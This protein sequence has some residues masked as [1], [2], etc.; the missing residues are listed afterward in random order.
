MLEQLLSSK[1]L[2]SLVLGLLLMGIIYLEQEFLNKNESNR[3]DLF[4]Y[5]KAGLVGFTIS[6]TSL[7]LYKPLTDKSSG[8]RPIEKILTGKPPF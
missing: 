3:F 5:L 1:L 7:M 2:I 4:T 8:L 6:L